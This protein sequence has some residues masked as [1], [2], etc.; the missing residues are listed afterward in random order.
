MNEADGASLAELLRAASGRQSED[1]S[2]G[3]LELFSRVLP[4]LTGP[5]H[6]LDRSRVLF[7]MA[8]LCR[9]EGR[10]DEALAHYDEL[11]AL[12]ERL[13]D[14]RGHGLALA[15]RGQLIFLRG[16]KEAGL[17]AM[18][19]GLEELRRANAAEAEHLTCHTRYFSRRMERV[20][21]ERCV[22]EATKEEAL[23]EALLNPDGC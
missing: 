2:A 17:R 13:A 5:E 9:Y 20:A 21:F 18:V 23:R 19:C 12:T 22:R 15:M 3:A 8:Q 11:L 6:A 1:D 10:E 4:L 7:Q 16:D 14:L